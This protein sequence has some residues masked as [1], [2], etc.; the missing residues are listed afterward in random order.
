MLE[1][2]HMRTKTHSFNS[3]LKTAS[4]FIIAFVAALF[5]V[6]IPDT[7]ADEDTDENSID[8]D[9]G[10]HY[11]TIYDHGDKKTVKSDAVTVA[12]V[13]ER[14][15]IEITDGDIV[16]PAA[17]T[18]ITEDTYNVN[19]YRAHP[20]VMID[21]TQRKYL[22]TASYD[23]K[24][25]A[26]AAGITVYDG[27]EIERVDNT[28]NFMESGATATYKLTRNGGRTITVETAIPYTEETQP[29]YTM[30]AGESKVTQV[31]EDG[32]KVTTYQVNFVDGKEVSRE[33][34][35]EEVTKEP[36]KQIIAQGA[37]ASVAPGQETCAQ[38]VRQAGVSDADLQ[39]ALFLIYHESGCR[40][41]AANKSSGA[42]GIPQALPGSKMSS[43]GA[44]WQTN[45]V[46]QIKW[47]A[48]YVKGRYGGWQQALAYWNTHHNY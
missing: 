35:S 44:D 32:R 12:E 2:K 9:T 5:F 23:P 10:A 14:A 13:L 42:Y 46:T 31:G 4:I 41:D 45:P 40:V 15:N 3:V 16:D 17:D 22:M 19:I 21:G 29:D 18:I 24:A 43:A 48:G 38:W 39:A 11:V 36:V 27:D 7:F 33:L 34:I 26:E 8:L 30:P 47:M 20:V 28:A 25:I 6:L 1:Y 37:K